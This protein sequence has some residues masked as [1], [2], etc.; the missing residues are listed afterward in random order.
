LGPT[1]CILNTFGAG[2]TNDESRYVVVLSCGNYLYT[3]SR[4]SAYH[5]QGLAVAVIQKVKY[6]GKRRKTENIKYIFGEK[7]QGS[8]Y[9]VYEHGRLD[10]SFI[11]QD[12][13]NSGNLWFPFFA[14]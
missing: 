8:Y 11:A 7:L 5:I 6:K 2:K 3:F 14:L 12:A 10:Y 4:C 1:I 13:C 9:P